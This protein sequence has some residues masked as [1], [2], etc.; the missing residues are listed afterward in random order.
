MQSTATL[1]YIVSRD[2]HGSRLG[3]TGPGLKSNLAGSGVYRIA[4]LKKMADQDQIGL[5]KFCCFNVI[6]LTIW[7]ILVVIRFVKW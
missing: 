6:F 1:V 4:G 5:K 7:K 2:E 3:R